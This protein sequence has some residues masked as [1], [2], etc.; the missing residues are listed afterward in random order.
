MNSFWHKA[1]VPHVGAVP[2]RSPR[3]GTL[4]PCFPAMS[5][6]RKRKRAV[7]SPSLLFLENLWVSEHIMYQEVIHPHSVGT[8]ASASETDSTNGLN[9][10]R[11]Q[12]GT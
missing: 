4:R 11:T 9:L 2:G 6:Q 12:I 1:K 8:E 3:P 10:A 7:F 5:L